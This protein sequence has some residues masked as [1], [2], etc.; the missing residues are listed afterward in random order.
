MKVRFRQTGGL[1]GLV[2]GCDLDTA[3]MSQS[4]TETLL[5]LI[6][7]AKLHEIGVRSDKRGRDLLSFEIRLEEKGRKVKA[8]FDTMTTPPH[9]ESL[10]RFLTERA[11]AIPLE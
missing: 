1:G 7:Q 3:T 10:L 9:A 2:F 4:E 6:Q 11:R 5:L 8:S